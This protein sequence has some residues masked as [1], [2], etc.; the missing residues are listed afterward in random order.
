MKS[1]LRRTLECLLLV[2]ILALSVAIFMFR[3]R[4][5]Q[6]GEVGYLGLMLLCFLANSTVLLPAPSLLLAASCALVLNPFCV[7]VFAALGSSLGELVGYLFGHTGQSVSPRFRVLMDQLE[8]RIHNPWLAVFILALLPLPLFDAVGI[9]SGGTKICVWKF[10]LFCFFG[11]FLKT[12]VYTR[13][14]DILAW[15]KTLPAVEAFFP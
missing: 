12:L 9:Y 10:L 3:D 2:L 5:A 6:I 15:A 1:A 7:A 4:F 11:K 8:R 13:F 14:Y